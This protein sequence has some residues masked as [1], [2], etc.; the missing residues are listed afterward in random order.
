MHI[1]TG[2]LAEFPPDMFP[3]AGVNIRLTFF[4]FP[5]LLRPISSLFSSFLALL[6]EKT[7]GIY[8]LE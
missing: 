2:I 4:L 6:W 1:K 3:I 8:E 7:L 5:S